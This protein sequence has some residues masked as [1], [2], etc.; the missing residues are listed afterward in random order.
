MD[1]WILIQHKIDRNSTPQIIKNIFK[2]EAGKAGHTHTHTLPLL[3]RLLVLL[4]ILNYAGQPVQ[5]MSETGCSSSNCTARNQRKTDSRPTSPLLLII[6]IKCQ[7]LRYF[8]TC[9]WINL[10]N[11][12]YQHTT[13]SCFQG[14]Q[15]ELVESVFLFDTRL[16][17]CVCELQ[18][19]FD[20]VQTS[21][22]TTVTTFLFKKIT[23]QSQVCYICFKVWT[24][25]ALTI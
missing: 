25:W 22:I 6:Y 1:G 19:L 17:C 15:N 4:I 24:K 18:L 23:K 12:V 9:W 20:Y 3:H 11:N 10:W 8:H 14:H 2:K 5:L 13:T 21:G 16:L 7:F